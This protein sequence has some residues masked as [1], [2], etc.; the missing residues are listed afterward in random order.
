MSHCGEL[1]ISREKGLADVKKRL[2][3]S[4]DEQLLN[5]ENLFQS[6]GA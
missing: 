2:H 6:A 5:K 4:E 3:T 1:R